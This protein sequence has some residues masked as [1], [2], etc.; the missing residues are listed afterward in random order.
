M[1]EGITK[2]SDWFSNKHSMATW[3]AVVMVL[4]IPL[5]AMQFT[6]EV[7]W[8]WLDF[9]VAGALLTFAGLG[10]ELAL[11]KLSNVKA[12]LAVWVAILT[13]LLIVWIELAIGIF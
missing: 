3:G 13:A 5:L 6:D 4:I 8:D 7:D 1:V 12:R 9:I 2:R 11:W 10:Y